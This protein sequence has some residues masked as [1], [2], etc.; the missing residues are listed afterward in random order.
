M[1]WTT[2]G[3]AGLRLEQAAGE[4]AGL[5]NELLKGLKLVQRTPM[6][7][8]RS[9]SK[10]PPRKSCLSRSS[11][12]R[13]GAQR[14]FRGC[15]GGGACYQGPLTKGETNR[16]GYITP[17][18]GVPMLGGRGGPKALSWPGGPSR[19]EG[20][21]GGGGGLGLAEPGLPGAPQLVHSPMTCPHSRVTTPQRTPGGPFEVCFSRSTFATLCLLGYFPSHVTHICAQPEVKRWL[22]QGIGVGAQAYLFFVSHLLT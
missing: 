3:G 21:W 8:W 18:Q 9:L 13:L 5:F 6:R 16:S 20:V 22:G 11:P 15:G 10:A 7:R 12:H 17:R 1:R 4:L 14:S 2:H 19:E